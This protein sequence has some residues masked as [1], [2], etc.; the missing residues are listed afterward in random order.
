MS[1]LQSVIVLLTINLGL[2]WLLLAAPVG[3][4][5]L[6]VRR[7]FRAGVDS[8]RPA[9][10]PRGE[11]SN[12][13]HAVLSSDRLDGG[14]VR[15]RL[16]HPDRKGEPIVRVLEVADASKPGEGIFTYR[17]RIIEDSALDPSFWQ[18]FREVRRLMATSGGAIVE[19]EQ[20]D[21]YRG[22]AF[23]L[24]RYFAL[25][26]ELKALD[27]WLK[28]GTSKRIATFEHPVTQTGLAALSTLLL[29]PFF[30]LTTHGLLLSTML[31]I[32]IVLHELGHMAA[33]RAFGHQRV[34]MIFV[35]FLGGI[36]IG[37]RP[38]N[39]LF[40]VASCALMGR[41]SPHSWFP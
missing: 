38:Y 4:R 39:S 12:W 8:I 26:R 27:G 14:L 10:D 13:Y 32:V 11:N 30:G 21:R 22:L 18:H 28:T 24:Y 3:K 17:S 2:I 1:T 40:E 37:G 19:V 16:T 5:T 20:T 23:L 33:Y 41:G 34:R 31:T 15:Q 36:A 9:L 7:S 29:W 35:P 6:T 25:S